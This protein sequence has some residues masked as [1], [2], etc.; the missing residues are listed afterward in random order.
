MAAISGAHAA[1]ETVPSTGAVRGWLALVALLVVAMIVVGGATRLTDSGLSITEWQPLL[2]AIPPLTD[3][4]WQEAFAK[5]QQIPEYHQVNKGMS[6]ADFKVIYWWEW[7]H[8]FLGR[9][10]GVVFALPLLAFWALGRLPRGMAGKLVGVLAL[11]GLQ[12]AIG[13]YMVKSGLVERVDV[14]HYRLALHLGTAFLIL[15]LVVWLALDLGARPVAIRLDTLTRAQRRTAGMLFGLL[16][17]QVLLGALV[18]GTKAGLAYNT[19]P[20]MDGR[21]VPDGLLSL[22]PWF[23]NPFENVA[24]I[25]FDHRMVAYVIAALA[26]W[27]ALSLRGVDDERVILSA[28]VLA[29]GVLA[30]IGLGVWTLLAAEGS[31]PIGLGL[32]HQGF[33]AVLFALSVWHLHRMTRSPARG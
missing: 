6:L 29:L 7:S 33:A 14:S 27:H 2:G 17:L 21:L 15:A 25:Q 20:L 11:G 23:M 28:S 1:G 3:A 8:R 18:A 31:I 13:W 22:S 26:L 30:Q 10:I 24:T 5:Y 9:I 32:A 19:W 12:G 4:H 16:F